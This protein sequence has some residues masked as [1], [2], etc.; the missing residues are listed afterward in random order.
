VASR[1]ESGST[2]CRPDVDHWTSPVLEII[3]IAADRLQI[4]A[5]ASSAMPAAGCSASCCRAC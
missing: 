4:A 2:P 1:N 5:C 3:R